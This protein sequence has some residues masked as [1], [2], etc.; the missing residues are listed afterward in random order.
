MS[1]NQSTFGVFF[2][3]IIVTRVWKTNELMAVNR[4]IWIVKTTRKYNVKYYGNVWFDEQS[5]IKVLVLKNVRIK[6]QVT[7]DSNND[8]V[9]RIHKPN[10]QDLHFDMN[11]Y[12]IQYHE[13]RNIHVTLV[14][15]FS[16][17]ESVYSQLHLKDTKLVREL[18]VKVGYPS[19]KDFKCLMK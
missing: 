16:E 1:N 5:I 9:F 18:Y 4:N 15:N 8:V 11:K 13:T 6:F 2:K 10:E 3:N 14:Q 17:N 19:Q 7:Y 12:I